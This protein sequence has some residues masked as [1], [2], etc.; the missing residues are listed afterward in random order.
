[1]LW[2]ISHAFTA[3]NLLS[4]IKRGKIMNRMTKKKL[5]LT[6]QRDTS[7]NTMYTLTAARFV[8]TYRLRAVRHRVGTSTIRKSY[9]KKIITN[10]SM[11][12]KILK[13]ID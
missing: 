6:K 11:L 13:K 3:Y 12:I 9:K 1:M 2:I 4:K 10:T 7:N 5:F 8:S